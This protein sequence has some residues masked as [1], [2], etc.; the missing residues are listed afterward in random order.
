MSKVY[1][2]IKITTSIFLGREQLQP[3]FRAIDHPLSSRIQKR[4]KRDDFGI[5]LHL[6]HRT[7]FINQVDFR[8]QEIYRYD[9]FIGTLAVNTQQSN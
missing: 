9:W 4:V 5:P 6:S 7:R 2:P 1:L 3:L 8:N